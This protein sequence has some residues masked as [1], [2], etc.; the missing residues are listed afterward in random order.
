MERPLPVT[1]EPYELN[2]RPFRPG[3]DDTAWL[4]VNR[5][6]FATHPIQGTM[7]QE[8]LDRAKTEPSFDP[9]GFVIAREGEQM[10]GFCWT[11][12]HADSNPPV[13]EIYV[14]GAHPAYQGRGLGRAL[15]LAGLDWLHGQGLTVGMLYVEANNEPALRLYLRLG[16][17]MVHDFRCWRRKVEA[18]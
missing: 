2:W 4:E 15:V 18:A 9:A 5:L 17:E 12:I 3:V 16:F 1:N 6:S 14:I 13:G 7:Q 8:D 10:T 11:K